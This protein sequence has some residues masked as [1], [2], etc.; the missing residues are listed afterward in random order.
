MNKEAYTQHEIYNM[1]RGLSGPE[2]LSVAD[3]IS[4]LRHR[5]QAA[6]K[7]TILKMEGSLKGYDIDLEDLKGFRQETWKHVDEEASGG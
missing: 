4:F 5:K 6:A 3:F 7:G 2:L 1:L